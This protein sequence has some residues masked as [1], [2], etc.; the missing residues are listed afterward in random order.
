MATL[1][2]DFIPSAPPPPDSGVL[3]DPPQTLQLPMDMVRPVKMCPE[4]MQRVLRDFNVE[5]DR[6]I[7]QAQVGH[8][9]YPLGP[10]AS[11]YWPLMMPYE[12]A[13]VVVRARRGPEEDA[14]LAWQ[15][16]LPYHLPAELCP[17]PPFPI[18]RF[19]VATEAAPSDAG[20]PRLAKGAVVYEAHKTLAD[21]AKETVVL[22]QGAKAYEAVLEGQQPPPVRILMCLQ[23]ATQ[24]RGQTLTRFI[25]RVWALT[26]VIVCL[27]EEYVA[28]VKE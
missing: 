24:R 25:D 16:T 22:G 8:L 21:M 12:A 14:P 5:P 11:A 3:P 20:H 26:G 27:S 6:H 2:L 13:Q 9:R 4:A 28:R 15:V 7:L 17:P 23:H 19:A 1:H 10:G 18:G